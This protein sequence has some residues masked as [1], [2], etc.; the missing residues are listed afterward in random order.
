MGMSHRPPLVAG[1]YGLR[2]AH[3]ALPG[4]GPQM[5]LLPNQEKLHRLQRRTPFGKPGGFLAGIGTSPLSSGHFPGPAAAG[6][7]YPR[8][9]NN[10]AQ[11]I[12]RMADS[13]GAAG[14]HQFCRVE[15]LGFILG[16][17]AEKLIAGRS[18]HERKRPGPVKS[19]QPAM[20]GRCCLLAIY[21]SCTAGPGGRVAETVSKVVRRS[22]LLPLLREVEERAGERRGVFI[23]NS[24]LLNPLPARSSRGGEEAKLSFETVSATRPYR[25]V[26]MMIIAGEWHYSPKFL[27]SNALSRD[28]ERTVTVLP[29]TAMS[30]CARNLAS[31]R[32]KVSPTVP[33]SA[34]STRLVMVNAT[35]TG[36]SPCGLG[37]RWTSQLARRV[38][39]SLSVRSSICPISTRK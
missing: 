31:V 17:G 34:A 9:G 5:Q 32:E 14:S 7:D 1:P 38:S 4:A 8:G 11:R 2:T 26:N 12:A 22:I 29:L 23:G 35:L 25:P 24:P 36:D 19:S 30:F 15:T 3:R 18:R 16:T 10:A 27:R 21:R 37:Q 39:T 20:V 28:G 6:D 33:S 13:R